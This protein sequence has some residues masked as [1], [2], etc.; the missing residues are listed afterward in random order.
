M[1]KQ[2]LCLCKVVK[3]DSQVIER[4]LRSV[5]HLIDHWVVCDTGS[6]DGTQD[7][8]RRTLDGIPGE[9]H[10]EPRIDFGSNCPSRSA[11]RRY[12]TASSRSVRPVPRCPARPAPVMGGNRP[13]LRG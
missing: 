2:S 11:G 4:C 8:I 10:E 12:S 13:P 1:K 9:L 5:R 7:L 6:T 3:N